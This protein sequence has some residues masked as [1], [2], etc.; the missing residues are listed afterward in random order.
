MQSAGMPELKC[1][2]DIEYMRNMLSLQ[3]TEMEA[4]AK[5]KKEIIN[6]M[7]SRIRTLDNFIHNLKHK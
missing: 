4:E 2:A 6:S 1:S 7:N 3:F 5:F